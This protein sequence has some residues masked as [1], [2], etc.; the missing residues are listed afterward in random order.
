MAMKSGYI[1][2]SLISEF[3]WVTESYRD[4]EKE[5]EYDNISEPFLCKHDKIF[6]GI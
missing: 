3:L 1:S 2:L 4:E 6:H 5:E